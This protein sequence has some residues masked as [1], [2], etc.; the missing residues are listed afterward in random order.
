M[1]YDNLLEIVKKEVYEREFKTEKVT[2]GA[3]ASVLVTKD[4]NIYTGVCVV[5][6][7]AL[8]TCAERSA[9]FQ[10]I[11]NNETEIRTIL[12]IGRNGY[13]YPPCGACLE[14][15]KLINPNNENTR[16]YISKDQ[17]LNLN[18]LMIKNWQDKEKM[19]KY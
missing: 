16:F 13:I 15:I 1:N 5:M 6:D 3:V 7:C 19:E 2:A 12:T 11:K 9:A 17:T 10:M 18:E 14:L 8:G 4:N